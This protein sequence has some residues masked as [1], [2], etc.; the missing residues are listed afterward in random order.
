MNIVKI[1]IIKYNIN[2][3][4]RYINISI[5]LLLNYLKTNKIRQKKVT[6][7]IL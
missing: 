7:L 1:K 4:P 3:F 6:N 5:I 2:Y